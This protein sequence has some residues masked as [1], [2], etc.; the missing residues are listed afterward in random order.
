MNAASW[1]LGPAREDQVTEIFRAAVN[2]VTGDADAAAA[3]A[4]KCKTVQQWDKHLQARISAA[5]FSSAL[6][7]GLHAAGII[8]ELPYL[9]RLMG[10]GAIGTGELAGAT[11]E[12]DA[13]LP[14]IFALWSGAVS[15]TALAS[16][17]GGVVIVDS[18]AYPQFGAKVLALGFKIGVKTAAAHAGIG[19]IAGAA[20][21]YGAGTAGT[22]L[23]PAFRKLLAKISAKI[24]AKVTAKIGAPASAKALAGL[25]PLVGAGVSTAISLHIL[26]EF[27]ASAKIY[28]EHKVN[29]A[30]P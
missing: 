1:A 11:I 29:D 17:A 5:A 9:F 3:E 7:P 19:G 30:T 4:R 14:A 15:K 20:I 12:A 10:R 22:M 6:I 23:Q 2:W 26:N 18:V 27:L 16:A 13:D 24:S 8:A 21:G 25:V 28:Y